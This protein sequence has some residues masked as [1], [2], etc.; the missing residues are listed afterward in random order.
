M[1]N[2][3][4]QQQNITPDV[5][6]KKIVVHSVIGLNVVSKTQLP[7]KLSCKCNSTYIMDYLECITHSRYST[8]EFSK[9]FSAQMKRC[10]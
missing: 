1:V 9:N 8:A 10:M 4:N 3:E 2:L 6:K 7:W 5:F